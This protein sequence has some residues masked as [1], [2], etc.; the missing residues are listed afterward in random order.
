MREVFLLG[1]REG[2]KGK[3][4]LSVPVNETIK[5]F[6]ATLEITLKFSNYVAEAPIIRV[7]GIEATVTTSAGAAG[8]DT[9]TA[10]VTVPKPP[11]NASEI[12]IVTKVKGFHDLVIDSDPS[13]PP[14]AKYSEAKWERYEPGD[15]KHHALRIK[16]TRVMLKAT[17]GKATAEKEIH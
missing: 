16:P 14:L 1:R 15:D 13:T 8:A 5:E 10:R 7:G 2:I 9:W 11:A 3:Q 12:K 17:L 4:K 6:P